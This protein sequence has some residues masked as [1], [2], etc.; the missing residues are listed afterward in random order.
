M[1]SED[2]KDDEEE[3]SSLSDIPE[4]C[5]AAVGESALFAKKLEGGELQA[6]ILSIVDRDEQALA[7]LYEAMAG[8]VYGLVQRITRNPQLAE[9]V[10]EDVFWQVWRQAPRYDAARGAAGTWIMTMARSRALDAL[11]RGEFVEED[12][13]DAVARA[14]DEGENDPIDLLSA[15][16]RNSQVHQALSAIDPLP[17]QLV[18][19]AFF[20]GLS[21]EEIAS[22][23]GLPLGTV[24]SHIRRAMIKLKAL[25]GGFGPMGAVTT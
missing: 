1:Y 8:K 10:T 4:A 18:A 2:P 6:L 5:L 23:T 3:S 14:E 17:R 21:H 7:V 24:K 9:E 19:L 16:E 22:H 20:K 11:R 13:S 25:L 12:N 15:V